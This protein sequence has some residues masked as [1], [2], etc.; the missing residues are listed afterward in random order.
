MATT[1]L[2]KDEEEDTVLPLIDFL[3]AAATRRLARSIDKS[4][5]RGSGAVAGF[6][7]NPAAAITRGGSNPS[8][9]TGVVTQAA[10]AG[11]A[12]AA[13]GLKLILLLLILLLLAQY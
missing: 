8:V 12:A 9:I 5:L 6:N 7:A 2:A 4:I 11:L 3:R 10:S 13:N 1:H